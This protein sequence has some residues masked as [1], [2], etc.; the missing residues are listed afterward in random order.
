MLTPTAGAM[1]LVTV[2]TME[3]LTARSLSTRLDRTDGALRRRGHRG[4]HGGS[5]AGQMR[6][7]TLSGTKKYFRELY[8]SLPRIS[9]AEVL[10]LTA[11]LIAA[12]LAFTRQFY[13]SF[14][15]DLKPG[16]IFL[17]C[18]MTMFL[19]KDEKGEPVVTWEMAEKNLM[20]GLFFLFAGGTALGALAGA[21]GLA[22]GAAG[23]RGAGLSARSGCPRA[24]RSPPGVPPA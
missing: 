9:R 11:F 24:C 12:G 1:N 3:A 7:K 17:I 2:V 22:A 6:G 20:W 16:F 13:Q 19:L 4:H 8:A 21:A 5:A 15:P 23:D 14:L 18:G 10:S